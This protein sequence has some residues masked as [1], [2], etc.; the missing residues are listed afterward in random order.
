[1]LINVKVIT[2]SLSNC[3]ECFRNWITYLEFIQEGIT[4]SDLRMVSPL[5]HVR[6]SLSIEGH[7][8]TS[9]VIVENSSSW[10]QG[11][12]M[13]IQKAYLA[14]MLSCNG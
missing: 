4:D 12:Q 9:S 1:M 3:E 8:I 6:N 11:L 5:I 2:C 7:F 14:I 13:S 10:Q